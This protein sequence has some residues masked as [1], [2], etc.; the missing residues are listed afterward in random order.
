MPILVTGALPSGFLS[1]IFNAFLIY[2]ESAMCLRRHT[3]LD[4]NMRLIINEGKYVKSLFQGAVSEFSKQV[5]EVRKTK[6]PGP[7]WPVLSHRWMDGWVGR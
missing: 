6:K 2:P 5:S 1:N 3:V 4:L 7:D